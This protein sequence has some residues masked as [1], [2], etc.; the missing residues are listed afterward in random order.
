MPYV[1]PSSLDALAANTDDSRT[2]R[3]VCVIQPRFLSLHDVLF[4]RMKVAAQW[5]R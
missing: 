1:Q 4:V 2:G 3:G 5:R